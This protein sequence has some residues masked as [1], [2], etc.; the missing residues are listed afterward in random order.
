VSGKSIDCGAYQVGSLGPIPWRLVRYA[1]IDVKPVLGRLRLGHAEKAD[2]G[3]YAGRVDDGCAIG[4]VVARLEHI[5]QCER[6]NVTA[7]T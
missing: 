2:G 3:A 5:V 1:D 4:V 6:Q 7:S